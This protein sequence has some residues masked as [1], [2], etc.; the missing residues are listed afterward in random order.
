MKVFE[1]TLRRFQSS[2]RIGF[3]IFS[4]YCIFLQQRYCMAKATL[5]TSFDKIK[6]ECKFVGN[7][8]YRLTFS[9]SEDGR[10]FDVIEIRNSVDLC[11]PDKFLLWVDGGRGNTKEWL[12]NPEKGHFEFRGRELKAIQLKP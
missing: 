5:P 10:T 6:T 12:Y 1:L 2:A 8:R 11:L 4:V 9:N 7:M 3:A